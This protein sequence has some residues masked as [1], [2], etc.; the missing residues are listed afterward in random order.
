[1]ST[2]TLYWAD[3]SKP[4]IVIP[5]QTI[6]LSSTSF[7]LY[8]RGA[9]SYGEGTQE[10]LL[11]LL[12]NFAYNIPPL[13]PTAGQM[14]FNTVDG[15]YT[16][17]LKVWDDQIGPTGDWTTPSNLD[18]S[19]IQSL[20]N[21]KVSKAGDTMTGFLT[22]NAD[23]VSNLQAATKQYVDTKQPA[24]GFTPVN[25]AGDTM[26]GLLTLSGD[27]TTNLQAATKQYVDSSNY[28]LPISTGS[29]L[30]GVKVGSNITESGDGTISLTPTNVISALGFTPGPV[31]TYTLPIASSS[32]LGGIKVGTGLSID[33]SG[34][35]SITPP[36]TTTQDFLDTYTL[37]YNFN[38]ANPAIVA[39]V[40][41]ILPN[42]PRA[43][44]IYTTVTLYGTTYTYYLLFY[45]SFISRGNYGA[46]LMYGVTQTTTGSFDIQTISTTWYNAGPAQIVLV[47][48]SSSKTLTI[49]LDV[50]F[51][52][53]TDDT[54]IM[55]V[56]AGSTLIDQI[57]SGGA[58]QTWRV[59]SRT[60][61]Q[62]LPPSS[63]Q[64]FSV[65]AT[66]SGGSDYSGA[67]LVGIPLLKAS[68]VSLI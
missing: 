10:N 7:K 40:P 5:D 25:K 15:T 16:R 67:D 26:T 44:G 31:Y 48:Y 39:P 33:P 66:V 64:T 37:I 23:P 52:T 51:I 34:I 63:K 60:Y 6:D 19:A 18:M 21:A 22:L 20:I 24:L 2:Y 58:G 47:N 9:R 57:V 27:P 8:G 45:D 62:T 3:S 32:V 14:W 12:E 41:I 17:G 43:N 61:T 54:A 36:T 13:H 38:T 29:V 59:F 46:N 35:L 65:S 1:M 55:D 4:P 56:Y 30:G 28:V 49:Q 53:N 68:Y 42:T 50:T 11:R